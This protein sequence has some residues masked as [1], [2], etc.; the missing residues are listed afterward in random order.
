MQTWQARTGAEV[1][2]PD[3]VA[4]VADTAARQLSAAAVTVVDGSCEG[5]WATDGFT[6]AGGTDTDQ[7]RL[8][9]AAERAGVPTGSGPTVRLLGGSS[10]GSGDVVVSL[11]VPYVLEGSRGSTATLALFGRTD[12]AFDALVAVLTGATTPQGALPVSIGRTTSTDC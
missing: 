1:A 7:Q 8:R 4:D 11:D 9:D 12:A 3:D 6:V 10:G 2:V 5:G